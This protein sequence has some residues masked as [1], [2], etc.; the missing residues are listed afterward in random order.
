M[1][2]GSRMD[3]SAFDTYPGI[4]F[5]GLGTLQALR[6][7]PPRCDFLTKTQSGAEGFSLLAT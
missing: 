2:L 3:V 4:A 1:W 6:V 7:V 5:R